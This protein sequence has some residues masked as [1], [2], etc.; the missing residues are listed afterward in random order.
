MPKNQLITVRKLSCGAL[1][2]DDFSGD[3]LCPTRWRRWLKDRNLCVEAGRGFQNQLVIAGISR[4]MEQVFALRKHTGVISNFF[5]AQSVVL[6]AFVRPA[7]GLS[8]KSGSISYHVH[9][10]NSFPDCYVEVVFAKDLAAAFEGPGPKTGSG[11]YFATKKPSGYDLYFS[12]P[13]APFGDEAETFREVKIEY[14]HQASLAR[15]YVRSTDCWHPEGPWIQLGDPVEVGF[16]AMLIELKTTDTIPGLYRDFRVQNCRLYPLP[17]TRPVTFHV[18]RWHNQPVEGATVRLKAL[19]DGQIVAEGRTGVWGRAAVP[20]SSE[21]FLTY[22]AEA[23]LEVEERG[24]VIG[25][26]EIHAHL[27]EGIYPGDVYAVCLNP[28]DSDITWSNLVGP[29]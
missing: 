28:A 20:L 27:T 21:S 29:I 2:A 26:R 25:S 12:E 11:W 6:A 24:Q 7:S 19:K 18:F 15:G 14:D 5:P 1:L 3:D 13:L 4:P 23:L 16:S 22:P 17:E 9:L 10:C 8:G